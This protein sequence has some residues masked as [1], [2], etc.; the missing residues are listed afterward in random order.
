MRESLTD[1]E[2]RVQGALGEA[3]HIQRELG[4]GG[5]SRVFLAEEIRLGRKVV[6]KVLPPEMAAGVNV[7]RFEREIQLA[8]RLQHPHIVP[9]L[10][11]GAEG[12]LLFYIM[13][14][15]EGES[16]RAKLAREG[17]LPVQ[18]SIRVLREVLDALRYAHGHRVVHRD[19]K[20]DNILLSDQHALVT[21]FGVAKAVSES[22]GSQTLTSLGVAVGT[23]AYMA[24]EQAA[25]EP[26]VDHRADIYAVGALAYEM[27]TGRPPFAGHTAQAVLMAHMTQ[28]PEPVTAHRSAVPAALNELILRCL[29]KKPADRWQRAEDVIPHLDGMLT[30]TGG[31]TPTATQPVPAVDYE[32]KA[33]QSHPVRVGALFALAAVGVLAIV[34]TLVYALGLPDW[35]F[36]CAIGLLAVGLPIILLTGHHER[37]RAQAQATGIQVMTPVGLQR[38]ATYRKALL[39]GG[40]A[41]G[42]LALLAGLFMISRALGI[43]PGATLLSAGVLKGQ[44]HLLLADF[45]NAS[46]DTTVA[47]TVTE[48]LRIDLAQSPTILVLQPAQIAEVLRRMRRDPA[49]PLSS[50]LAAEVATR[51]GIKAFVAG[52]VRSV[53]SG[54]VVS[55]RLVEASSGR[56][57]VSARETAASSEELIEAVDH[58]S[59]TLRERIGESL[60]TL[61]ADPPLAQLTTASLA[62]LQ[63]Y[64]QAARVADQGDYDRA[65]ALLQ[66][67]VAHDSTFAM[68]WRRIGAYLTNP[69]RAPAHVAIGRAALE[70]AYELRERL[71]DRERLFV[72]AMY[73]SRVE[74]NLEKSITSYLAILEKQ[75]G[76]PIALNNL[77]TSYVMSGRGDEA[78]ATYWRLV[79]AGVAPS[80][81]YGN[82]VNFQLRQGRPDGADSA[83]RLFAEEYV[84]SAE[85]GRYALNLAL[86]RQ[87]FARAESTARAL[88]E[89]PLEYQE[90]GHDRIALVAEIQGRLAEADRE[91]REALRVLAE[92]VG[93]SDD[94]R[95][96]Q[97]ELDLISRRAWYDSERAGLAR[98]LD[99]LW[100]RTRVLTANRRPREYDG[101]VWAYVRAGRAARA[102]QL[103]DEYLAS[104]TPADRANRLTRFF[105]LQLEAELLVAEGRS[106]AAIGKFRE[107]CDLFRSFGL[108]RV[109]AYPTLAE[110]YDRAGQADS[111]IAIYERFLDLR[112][113]HPDDA[114][115]RLAPSLR[116]VGEL[117]E[118]K[119]N[120]RKAIEYYGRFV[121]LW[122]N[123]DPELQSRIRDVQE[124]IARLAK[125]A[126]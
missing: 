69:D 119:G 9:L 49:R 108:C 70:R 24:P 62:A 31:L 38:H 123:A 64:A 80:I 93:M 101:F 56:A 84:G 68:A 98:R 20:P 86:A 114:F 76:E 57:L 40:I 13:P 79:E 23:P 72:E 55:A 53:G 17:E 96:L 110:A 87:E 30:P 27:L 102:R 67:A 12:D 10:S 29:E 51:E 88:L 22:T 15:I 117:Y 16:L 74:Q 85:I 89:A 109:H 107:A 90:L 35:V 19:I 58:L 32:A 50:D 8:A 48:L 45:E 44:E 73:Q 116:R 115:Q 3:Y 18:E 77:G 105:T 91:R 5:M 121:Q 65:V 42:A 83:L 111:A 113:W 6:V 59:G 11:A 21:D 106:D 66:Q 97:A 75:P 122:K 126:G 61:R 41:F 2:P 118:A 112:A 25:G 82:L 7:D 71:S 54:Y 104:Q 43:G 92:R 95:Q 46:G 63:L 125:E 60:R 52:E 100:E 94:E 124:R 14:F 36:Y 26:H 34:Y 103:F 99:R 4:G 1:L 78:V 81:T 39:G 47:E 120:A 33:R 28:S 37:Q